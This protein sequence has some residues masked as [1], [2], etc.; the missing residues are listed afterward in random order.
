[1]I[2]ILKDRYLIRIPQPAVTI[3]DIIRGY[4]EVKA[5]KPEPAGTA[6]AK[7]PYVSASE[8]SGE[9]TVFPWMIQVIMNIAAPRIV[10]NPNATVIYMRSVGMSCAI[11]EVAILF[12]WT[13]IFDPRRPMLWNVCTTS[14][15][16]WP[17]SV[18]FVLSYC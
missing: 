17:A 5:S 12:C 15:N 11:I 10:A 18:G 13:T 16:L 8:A 1:M 7:T 3:T 9:P 6:A 4:R 2:R 14:A